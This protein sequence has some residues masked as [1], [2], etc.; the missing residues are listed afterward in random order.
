MTSPLEKEG[1]I[2]LMARRPVIANLMMIFL[3][4]G[5][6]TMSLRIKQEVFPEFQLDLITISVPYPGASPEEVERGII[7]SIEEEVRGLDGVKKVS[8]SAVEGMGTVTV[9]LLEGTNANKALQDVKNVIDSITTF[10]EDAERPII[11]LATSR[12]QVISLVLYGKLSRHAMRNLAE[13]VRDELLG[14]KG[15]TL[16]D[17]AGIRPMEI[18]IEIPRDTL[19]RYN[20]TLAQVAQIIRASSLE[21]PGGGVRTKAGEILLRVYER[22]DWGRQFHSL[23]II[24]RPDGS[25]VLL[26]DIATIRD[27]F[28]DTDDSAWFN[29]QPAIMLNVYRLGKQTPLGVSRIVRHYARELK[30]RLP[31]DV[32]VATWNDASEIYADRIRLLLKNGTMGLLLV[33]LLLGAFLETR[34]AFW[35]AMGIPTSVIGSLLLM[36]ILGVSIN[37]ISLFAFI[38]TLGIVVDDAIIVGEN[39]YRLRQEGGSFV[40][41]A[42]VGTKQIAVPVVFSV[43]TNIVAFVPMLFVPGVMGKI[44]KVIPSVVI[45]VFAISLIEALLIL[46]AHLAHASVT[47]PHGAFGL[48]RGIQNH[49]NRLLS[50]VIEYLYQ[51]LIKLC[52]THRYITFCL[53][54]GLL[55]L[56]VGY[57]KSGRIS[58]IAIPKIESDIAAVNLVLPFGTPAA[59]TR[60]ILAHLEDCANQLMQQNGG[61]EKISRGVFTR[62]GGLAQGRKAI[63]RQSGSG[64]GHLGTVQIF[65]VKRKFRSFSTEDFISRWRKLAGP[66]PGVESIVFRSDIGGPSAGNAINIQLSHHNLKTLEVA[67]HDLAL[68]LQKISGV[69]DVDDGFSPGKIQL[70]FRILPAGRSLGLT[71]LE[72]GRQIR[73]AYYSAEALRQQRGR[74]E[75]KVM[76]RFPKIDREHLYSVENFILRAPNGSEIPFREAAAIR[77][78][79]A[80][81]VINRVDGR[82]TD[83]VTADV[84]PQSMTTPVLETIRN[85]PLPEILKRYP[86]L[87]FSLEGERRE[88][89]DS[90]SSLVQGFLLAMLVIFAM[91]AIPFNSYTQPLIIMTAIPFGIVGAVIGHVLMG[92]NL[93]IISMMGIVA[94]SGVVVN[95]S[96]VLIDFTNQ[97]RNQKMSARDAL[98]TAG[99]RRFRPILLTSLSTFFGLMPMI[100]ETSVQARFLIPMAISLGY[101]ILFATGITLLFVPSLYLILDDIHN[102]HAWLFPSIETAKKSTIR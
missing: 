94:L 95:D 20:L 26:S 36:P 41:A 39:V 67:A 49:M 27:G 5:G 59:R 9:E 63:H 85:G 76:V 2:G 62:V 24:S 83:N 97:C 78:G 33:V 87:T 60:E 56:T 72:V 91:L 1:L 81:T 55:L 14:K 29:G 3:L 92:Y 31:A 46:P 50:R 58:L 82:R 70:N 30:Q 6:L 65:F 102:L 32:G 61:R 51:P 45:L 66:I 53:G 8:A 34:L 90:M 80:Y 48:L 77:P 71:P 16:V 52:L 22:R 54:M 99:M 12:H 101:G 19:R 11:N 43:L 44:F 93:S 10:P 74:N 28:A 21:L 4:V 69:R 79:R 23:P 7:E 89:R 13:N 100:F 73:N 17:L 42:I 25:R 18:S 84:S 64:G 88:L 35:V 98:I 40:D 47:T 57:V 15:I 37:M 38:I 68:R 75:L 96:L 86:G